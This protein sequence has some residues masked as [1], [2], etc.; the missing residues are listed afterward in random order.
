M[1]APKINAIFGPRVASVFWSSSTSQTDPGGAWYV[2]FMDGNVYDD[3][4]TDGSYVRAV[5][6]GP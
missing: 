2:Y 4:K 5:R 3:V 6:T 1:A